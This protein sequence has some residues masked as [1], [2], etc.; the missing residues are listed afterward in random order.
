MLRTFVDDFLAL[1]FFAAKH[2]EHDV[3][4]FKSIL[5]TETDSL[6]K[7]CETWEAKQSDPKESIPPEAA[8]QIRAVIGKANI[9]MD[10]KG[11]C[12]QFADLIHKCEFNLGNKPTTCMDLQVSRLSFFSLGNLWNDPTAF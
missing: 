3:P 1:C 8:G 2:D 7:L 6:R 5:K 12:Q 10:K 9:F 11:R 4:Y